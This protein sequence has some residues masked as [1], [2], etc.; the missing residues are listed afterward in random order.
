MKIYKIT[1]EQFLDI[2]ERQKHCGYY[3]NFDKYL[4]EHED[5]LMFYDPL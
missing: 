4:E 5:D 3:D 1:Q 2:K